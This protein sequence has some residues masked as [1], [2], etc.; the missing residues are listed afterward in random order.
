VKK[1]PASAPSKRAAPV[2]SRHPAPTPGP[3]LALA[4]VAG[5]LAVG[6][7]LRVVHFQVN[8]YTPD[9]DAYAHF[10][11]LPMH[12]GGLGELPRLVRE[13]NARPDMSQ[14]PP[15][16][17]VG[18]LWAIVGLMD[19]TASSTIQTAACVSAIASILMLLL[20]TRIGLGFL[21]AWVAV[22]ALLFAVVSPLDLALARRVWG[23]ELVALLAL[24]AAWAF[25]EHAA[26]GRHRSWKIACL[27][28][29]GYSILVKET[30]LLLLALATIGL[31]AVAW[32]AAGAR[33][34]AG[35]LLGG[36]ITLLVSL[37]TIAAACGGL[38]PFLATLARAASANPV[39]AYSRDY[40]S[41]GP[42]YYARG[43]ALLQPLPVA[44]GLLSAA[45]AAVRA[46]L[47]CRSWESPRARGTLLTLAWLALGV[48]SVALAWP[49]KNMR[50][51]SPI[52]APL[53]LLAASLL[54]SAM[55]WLR[56]RWPGT[57]FRV[58]VALGAAVLL[59]AAFADHQRFV[60]FFIRRG[61]P[62]LATPWFL[63][64]PG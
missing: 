33:G 46:P 36:L 63:R 56:V 18:H 47:M 2:P 48:S 44:L 43:L 35:A 52:Y 58:G 21:N 31:A 7:A 19:L 53:D 16:T 14:Y 29:S 32:R 10:Y 37:A 50:F 3:R 38:E 4:L 59:A 1:R 57:P 5:L 13:Y 26:G 61:I 30:G 23:D 8:V 20:I 42:L 39:T 6:I 17:R 49:L 11:A 9:E 25:L 45:L 27:A 62:D 15:P 28:F 34:A 22:L 54:G 64:A 40:Q 60:E 51:L 24:A 12:S 41:G 55:R